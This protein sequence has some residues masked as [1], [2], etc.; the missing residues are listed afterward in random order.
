MASVEK[1]L[2]AI[3]QRAKKDGEDAQCEV[4][5]EEGT[6]RS[7][8]YRNDRH[9]PWENLLTIPPYVPSLLV[10]ARLME[11]GPQ[12]DKGDGDGDDGALANDD[13]RVVA[14][15]NEVKDKVEELASAGTAIGFL[16]VNE[17]GRRAIQVTVDGVEHHV[18]VP[19]EMP[20]AALEAMV[21]LLVGA[22]PSP[23]AP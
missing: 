3:G 12:G 19:H 22:G 10:E 5:G 1:T 7:V 4:V 18:D 16:I 2:A 8:H 21:S 9:D 6:S 14:L 13:P 11:S 17:D 23:G 15:L 20:D